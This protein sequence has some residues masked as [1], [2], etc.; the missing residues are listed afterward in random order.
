LQSGFSPF[1]THPEIEVQERAFELSQLL[2]FVGA[3][4]ASHVPPKPK[5]SNGDIPEME[6]GFEET[7]SD[8]PP[9]PKSLFLFQPLFAAHELNAV[10]YKAQEAV[11]IPERLDLERD[12]V[13]GGGFVDLGEDGI[14]SEEE[15]ERMELGQGGGAGMEELR[16]VMRE[17]EGRKKKGK[18]KKREEELTA[19]ERKE[20]ERVSRPGVLGENVELIRRTAESGEESEAEG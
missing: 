19:E 8:D 1:L 2:S 10:A 7:A 18:G 5:L 3:D 4:L 11:R 13:P 15:E 14:E 17:Q 9:Y 16:R 6:S 12:I 20:K